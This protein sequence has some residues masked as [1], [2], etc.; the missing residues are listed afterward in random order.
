MLLLLKRHCLSTSWR[1]LY[2]TGVIAGQFV[3]LGFLALVFCCPLRSGWFFVFLNLDTGVAA[4]IAHFLGL[5]VI[6]EIIEPGLEAVTYGAVTTVINAAGTVA[7]GISNELLALWD[8]G[9][10]A[11]ARDDE[12]VRRHI[13]YLQLVCTGFGLLALA[14]IPVLPRQKDECN[15]LRDRPSSKW[16][17]RGTLALIVLGMLWGT[18]TSVLPLLPF[19]CSKLLGGSGCDDDGA[20]ADDSGG[21]GGPTPA[22]SGEAYCS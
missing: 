18:A 21:G 5:I 19:G 13:T 20:E 4:D 11:I 12:A 14:F 3:A 9:N 16:A 10:D 6:P 17:S 1:K 8:L 22:P 2:G 15:K 7:A